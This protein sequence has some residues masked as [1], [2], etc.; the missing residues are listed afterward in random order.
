MVAFSSAEIRSK[1]IE[2]TWNINDS[3]SAAPSGSTKSHSN[4]WKINIFESKS[5][6][7]CEPWFRMATVLAHVCKISTAGRRF[8][9]RFET[10]GTANA[11]HTMVCAPLLGLGW[12]SCLIY[13]SSSHTR[14]TVADRQ[15]LCVCAAKS[16]RALLIMFRTRPADSPNATCVRPTRFLPW[17]QVAAICSGPINGRETLRT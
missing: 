9:L 17:R 12:T 7:A 11:T 14:R 1:S 16:I 4:Q 13:S 10:D 15:T 6:T 5:G 3:K 2:N 8:D